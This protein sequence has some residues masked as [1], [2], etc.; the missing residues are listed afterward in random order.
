ML[1]PCSKTSNRRNQKREPS[2]RCAMARHRILA[3][4]TT[5]TVLLAVGPVCPLWTVVRG[6]TD[7]PPQAGPTPGP[8][9]PASQSNFLAEIHRTLKTQHDRII[10]LAN[11]S[12]GARGMR[13]RLEDQL[14]NQQITTKGVEAA[15]L[16]AR[17]TR[18]VAE[19]AVKEYSEM[20]FPQ[21]KETAEF[22]V[23]LSRDDVDVTRNSVEQSNEQLA[24]IERASQGSARDLAYEFHCRDMVVESLRRER[25]APLAVEKAESKLRMLI[26]YTK[27]IRVHQLQADIETARLEELA[28]RAAF[29]METAKEHRLSAAASSAPRGADDRVLA[30][31]DKA[32]S[33]E[34]QLRSKLNHVAKEGNLG[35]LLQ[36]EIRELTGQ[37]QAIVEEAEAEQC[38]RQF[39]DL[40]AR[41]HRVATQAGATTN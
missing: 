7:E 18:E 25:T 14:V 4:M 33:I 32:I 21:D 36:K 12:L 37:L 26:E 8:T 13:Q 16:N 9:R 39:D 10:E 41:I 6:A 22:E 11:Q 31:L 34:E 3:V 2:W 29:E 17:L 27:P 30:L 19:I 28:K 23:R 40:K 1:G 20:T 24:K 38:A 5:F 35:S 15:Y